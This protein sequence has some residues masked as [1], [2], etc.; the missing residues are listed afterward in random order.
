LWFISGTGDKVDFVSFSGGEEE[1][2]SPEEQA[3][4]LLYRVSEIDLF[5]LSASG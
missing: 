4:H 2:S 5:H 1:S 3:I